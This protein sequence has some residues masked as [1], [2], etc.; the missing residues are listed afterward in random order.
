M[1]GASDIRTFIYLRK[2]ILDPKRRMSL[3]C[4]IQSVEMCDIRRRNLKFTFRNAEL[5]VYF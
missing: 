5:V 4:S 1:Y 2:S 3:W